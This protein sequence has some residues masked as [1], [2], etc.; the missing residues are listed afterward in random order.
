MKELVIESQYFPPVAYFVQMLRFEQV[1]VSG[2][3]RFE[4]Q[5]YRNR[6]CILTANKVLSLVVPVQK[7]KSQIATENVQV[8]Y[9][10]KWQLDHLRAIQSAYGKAPYFAHYF[11]QIEKIITGQ[12]HTIFSLNRDTITWAAQLLGLHFSVPENAHT[13]D[14]YDIVNAV[15]LI[16]PKREL[17]PDNRLHYASEKLERPYFQCFDKLGFVPNLS[18][19]DLVMNE[20]P[21]SRQYIESLL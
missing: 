6:C 16:H 1:W 3:E 11:P 18:I 15:S 4:K 19:I 2:Q 17:P 7:G 8:V 9:R 10:E 13:I 21:T 12:Y 14:G 5:S 20:G